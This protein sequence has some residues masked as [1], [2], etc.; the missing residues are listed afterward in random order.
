M[1]ERLEDGSGRTEIAI[2]D[3]TEHGTE[4]GVQDD[5]GRV[6]EGHD[7]SEGTNVVRLEVHGRERRL[8]VGGERDVSSGPSEGDRNEAACG[9]KRTSSVALYAVLTR[10]EIQR[11]GNAPRPRNV[12]GHGLA[13]ESR[14]NPDL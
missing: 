12:S 11:T 14:E 5:V 9:R 6:Q 10:R 1:L 2:D 8:N 13:S 4:H 3:T 7:G